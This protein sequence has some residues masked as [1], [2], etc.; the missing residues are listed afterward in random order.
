MRGLLREQQEQ[1]SDPGIT[2]SPRAGRWD[3]LDSK[4][5]QDGERDVS[6]EIRGKAKEKG[7]NQPLTSI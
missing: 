7:K 4:S 6:L 1:S 5:S 3:L 2:C